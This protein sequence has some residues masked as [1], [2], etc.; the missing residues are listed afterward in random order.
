MDTVLITGGAGFLGYHLAHHFARNGVRPALLDI[1]PYEE[2]EY[3]D[4]TLFF[5]GDV[6]NRDE[7]RAALEASRP[8]WVIHGAAALPL[9]KRADIFSV[10]V[11]GTRTVLDE[12][13]RAGVERVAHVSSTAVYGVPK[14][15]PIEETD[16]LSR[17][18]SLRR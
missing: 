2:S 9:W 17:R 4:G 16:P 1:A 12:S 3:P 18:R 14:K 15:H 11:D 6:R 7:V 13:F 8:R 10:N 5:K